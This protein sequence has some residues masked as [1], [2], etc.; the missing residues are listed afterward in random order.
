[1]R[2][3]LSF[4]AERVRVHGRLSPSPAHPANGCRHRGQRRKSS[5]VFT[6]HPRCVSFVYASIIQS[7][8]I[9]VSAPSASGRYFEGAHGF[10]IG[11]LTMVENHG[12]DGVEIRREEIRREEIRREEI[13]REEIR[14]EEVRGED[15]TRR[16]KKRRIISS[17]GQLI[18]LI[19]VM[20]L[21]LKH[22]MDGAASNDASR[23]YHP[24]CHPGTREAILKWLLTWFNDASRSESLFLLSGP[25]GVGKSAIMLKYTEI[26]DHRV[27]SVFVS[28]PNK[29]NDPNRIFTTI[30]Y[31]LA[32]QIEA[33]RNYI[34]NRVATTPDILTKDMETQ[35]E[36]FI[37]EPFVVRKVGTGGPP[38]AI[39]LD[40][41]D[42]VDGVDA[43]RHIIRLIGTF[44]QDHPDAP[45]AWIIASRPEL[46]ITNMFKETP[47]Q[48]RFKSYTL[49]IDDP[50]ARQD[51]ATF[52]SE[53]FDSIRG[54]FDGVIPADWPS[55]TDLAKLTA[56]SSGLFIFAAT[57]LR[58]IS[59]SDHSDPVSRL[60]IVLSVI[61]RSKGVPSTE[62]P[63]RNLDNLYTEILSRIPAG[64]LRITKLL[65]R[66]ALSFRNDDFL[67]LYPWSTSRTPR[68]MALILQLDPDRVH[69]ALIKCIST[70][71]I[72]P[73][74]EAHK[75]P[76]TFLHASFADYLTDPQRSG[77]FYIDV[78]GMEDDVLLGYLNLWYKYSG[79]NSGMFE[80]VIIVFEGCLYW[81]SGFDAEFIGTG[82]R[83]LPTSEIEGFTTG[84]L[85]DM[86]DTLL[87]EIVKRH[88]P[89]QGVSS[90]LQQ[91]HIDC[92][93]ALLNINLISLC[94]FNNGFLTD[95]SGPGTIFRFVDE[96]FN[97]WKVVS[98][99]K[100]NIH[101]LTNIKGIST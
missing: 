17:R 15:E 79:A 65:L 31:R 53:S 26:A 5:F 8:F 25:A 39:L 52:L 4:L 74:E 18:H 11:N 86:G 45:L 7:D 72:P 9:V 2:L 34:V 24:R 50:D 20:K 76:L 93:N 71:K 100:L 101:C 84:I 46:H 35:F 94:D 68:G 42:E 88:K 36:V 96:A 40:G 62:Q 81:L 85:V 29:C 21:L 43:Q 48:G 37:T 27:I 67:R 16:S 63:F 33:Y 64:L 41:L 59:D 23:T 98:H 44:M 14:R 99:L 56:A 75:K 89:H 13:R 47:M 51:V 91:K 61:D 90:Q 57:A 1:V 58:F 69:P 19:T 82:M 78:D 70:L 87:T 83:G 66:L 92:F 49:S 12:V 22:V 80:Y 55:K 60:D 6:G 77:K 30:G 10:T 97:A 3:W 28:R 73:R 38:L 95:V 32:D 54:D